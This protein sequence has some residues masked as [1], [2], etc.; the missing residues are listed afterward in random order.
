MIF[1]PVQSVLN[2]LQS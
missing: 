2:P 1:F